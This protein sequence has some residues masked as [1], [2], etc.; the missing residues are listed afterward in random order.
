MLRKKNI[1]VHVPTIWRPTIWR[2]APQFDAFWQMVGQTL[3]KTYLFAKIAPQF[4]GFWQVKVSNCGTHYCI[5]RKKNMDLKTHASN[6]FFSSEINFIFKNASNCGKFDHL[7]K[8]VNLW[9]FSPFKKKTSN[10]G[11]FSRKGTF[12]IGK[13]PQKA[14]N[15]GFD[16]PFAKKRQIVG[17]LSNCGAH[18]WS[19]LV[20]N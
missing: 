6:F 11:K 7:K 2:F 4:D 5:L 17:T 12:F 9:E 19:S 1:T 14:S 10:C 16:R 13:F 20:L 15:C 8:S 3:W 18:D